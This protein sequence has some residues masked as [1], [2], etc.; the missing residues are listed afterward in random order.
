MLYYSKDLNNACLLHFYLKEKKNLNPVQ[1]ENF[2]YIPDENIDLHALI[3]ELDNDDNNCIIIRNWDDYIYYIFCNELFVYDAFKLSTSNY[4]ANIRL[5]DRLNVFKLA[6]HGFSGIGNH[7]FL[8]FSTRYISNPL[9]AINTIASGMKPENEYGDIAIDYYLYDNKIV[10]CVIFKYPLSLHKNLEEIN[11]IKN[12]ILSLDNV[13]SNLSIFPA[14]Q[15]D[16]QERYLN[17]FEP[18]TQMNIHYEGYSI[19]SPHFGSKDF[20]KAID[21][22]S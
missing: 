17:G 22:I 7:V 18:A 6:E 21:V 16:F 5:F 11:N 15:I 1:K 14:E 10:Y 20:N 19:F 4:D 13:C 2:V 12:N 3:G 8:Y 9:D